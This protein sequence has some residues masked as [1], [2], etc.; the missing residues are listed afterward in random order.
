VLDG[1]VFHFLTIGLKSLQF[2]VF[3]GCN[4]IAVAVEKHLVFTL[5]V[6]LGFDFF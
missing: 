3:I 6:A 1:V 4:G 2:A 5:E